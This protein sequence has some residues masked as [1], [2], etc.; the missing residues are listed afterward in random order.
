MNVEQQ[1]KEFGYNKKLKN[2]NEQIEKLN[3]IINDLKDEL[4]KNYIAKEKEKEMDGITKELGIDGII[5]V[6]KIIS[7]DRKTFE[8][9]GLEIK[10]Q[11]A[12]V[13]IQGKININK[14]KEVNNVK[15]L[16]NVSRDNLKKNTRF[17][18]Y[19][20][21]S[22]SLNFNRKNSHNNNV[23]SFSLQKGKKK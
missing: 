15:I 14:S 20:D 17:S 1:L 3:K 19:K 4:N 12:E 21:S 18:A 7:N 5:D 2:K 23:V 11:V 8:E 13:F 10:K 22:K 6:K 9:Y 16:K